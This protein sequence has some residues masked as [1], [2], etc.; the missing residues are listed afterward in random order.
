[1]FWGKNLSLFR[2]FANLEGFAG[3]ASDKESA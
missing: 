3:G 2:E 1:M